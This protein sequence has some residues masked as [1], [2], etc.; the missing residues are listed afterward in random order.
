MVFQSNRKFVAFFIAGIIFSVFVFVN[1]SK[2]QTNPGLQILLSG[3]L[4]DSENQEVQIG[5]FNMN[6]ALYETASSTDNIWSEVFSGDNKVIV[7]N[8]IFQVSLG[9]R[10]P[11]YVDFENN[12][13]LLGVSIGGTED[14]PQWDEEMSPRIAVTTL[15]NLLFSGKII[16]TEEELV[17]ALIEEF[18]NNSSGTDQLTQTAFINFLKQKLAQAGTSAVIISPNTISLLLEEVLKIQEEYEQSLEKQTFWQSLLNFF[19]EIFDALAEKLGNISDKIGEIFNRLDTIDQG[20]AKIIN[21]LENQPISSTQTIAPIVNQE[22]SISYDANFLVKDLGKTMLKS[23]E[24]TIRVF[25]QYITENTKIFILPIEEIQDIWWISDRQIGNY[26]EISITQ[27]QG[28][29]LNFEYWIIVPKNELP[30]EPI[31][32]PEIPIIE[33][34]PAEPVVPEDAVEENPTVEIIE[35]PAE[36]IP[37]ETPLEN[38]EIPTEEIPEEIPEAIEEVTSPL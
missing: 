25:S 2:A 20:V 13:Y 37:Q 6:F 16:M 21:I 14:V 32:I 1:F 24:T 9:L 35:A 17:N 12:T 31:I 26:F 29:D 15:K 18:K 27:S 23:G 22:P 36:E 8:G 34:A 4:S 5:E 7:E 38:I 3:K 11:F 28:Q 19:T 30:P 33:T 10:N